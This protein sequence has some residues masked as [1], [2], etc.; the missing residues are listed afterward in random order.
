MA[1]QRGT[2]EITQL[3]LLGCLW[4][5]SPSPK[6]SS[7][8]CSTCR[9]SPTGQQLICWPCSHTEAS[10]GPVAASWPHVPCLSP[11][12]KLSLAAGR[13]LTQWSAVRAQVSSVWALLVTCHA[14]CNRCVSY[15]RASA[16]GSAPAASVLGWKEGEFSPHLRFIYASKNP[17]RKFHCII[18]AG[19]KY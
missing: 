14:R 2:K 11:F 8:I 1:R 15:P 19:R 4:H 16:D 3:L 17:V 9:H 12:W 10:T 5:S 6:G 13:R 18:W 7:H